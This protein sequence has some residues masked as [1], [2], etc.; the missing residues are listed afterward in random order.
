MMLGLLLARQGID[1]TVLE[2]HG[3]FLRDFRGDTVHPSTMDLLDQLGLGEKF[4]EIPQGKFQRLGL[5]EDMR[6]GS[7]AELKLKHPYI[8]IAP[9]WDFL[10]L[11][12]E[13]ARTYPAFHLLMRSEVTGAVR[14]GA[15]VVGV[16]YRDDVGEE[17]E[18]RAELT[19]GA[20]GRRSTIRESAGLPTH[21]FGA[22][23]DVLWFRLSKPDPEKDE[24]YFKV[25]PYRWVVG[26]DRR[27]YIQ[28]AYI[29]P[30]G[31]RDEVQQAGIDQF[32][33]RLA[34]AM[35]EVADRVDELKSFDDIK[36]LEVQV[37]R[38][39]RWHLPGLLLIGDSAHAMSPMGGVGVNY[40]IQD[41]V[42]ASNI[43]SGPLKEAQN[44]GGEI[45][46]RLLRSVQ[47]RR[48]LPTAVIQ[49]LQRIAQE[50]LVEPALHGKVSAVPK[51]A[52]IMQR[53]GPLR[54]L[55]LR[56][57]VVGIRQERIETLPSG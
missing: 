26:F 14:E 12:V 7:I 6:L 50:R 48:L 15:R 56:V 5:R 17:K 19:V 45:P 43:L 53:I 24:F 49:L 57:L 13:E 34:E 20:D 23:F 8:A 52:R 22:P 39:P 2:K 55:F 32:R 28:I 30:K 27:T 47:R 40:A 10:N 16:R 33:S 54:R 41:A 42:A 31:T 51:F 46:E 25:V 4:K 9:Q 18:L 44:L 29:I 35:P 11:L 3:D 36:F 21:N 38:A 1:I 37:N